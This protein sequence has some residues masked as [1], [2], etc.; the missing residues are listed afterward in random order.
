MH[1]GAYHHSNPELSSDD[2]EDQRD[3]SGYMKG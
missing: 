2:N 3:Y 1:T